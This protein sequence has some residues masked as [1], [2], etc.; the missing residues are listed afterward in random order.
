M[1]HVKHYSLI[2][3]FYKANKSFKIDQIDINSLIDLI[4]SDNKG[5]FIYYDDILYGTIIDQLNVEWED[6][7]ILIIAPINSY[8]NYA[9][10]GF[11][12]YNKHS[13]QYFS[14]IYSS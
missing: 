6:D 7:K 1:F 8:S 14:S 4:F 3:T 10:S 12:N 11:N 2:S 13:I 9:P 5:K